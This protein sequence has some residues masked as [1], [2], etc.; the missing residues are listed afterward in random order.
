MISLMNLDERENDFNGILLYSKLD[1]DNK[2]EKGPVFQKVD[3][4]PNKKA[5]QIKIAT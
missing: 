5:N 3:R 2:K 1:F 4:P